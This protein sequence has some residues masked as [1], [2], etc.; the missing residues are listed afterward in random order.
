MKV[1]IGVT[2]YD[3]TLVSNETIALEFEQAE[4][5]VSIVGGF[6]YPLFN[7]IKINKTL[8]TQGR[9]QTFLHEATHAMLDEIGQ[10]ELYHDEAFVNA[11]SKQIYGLFKNNNFEK[12]YK[13]LGDK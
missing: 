1:Q 5:D 2:D 13:F 10:E 12:I 9:I 7:Q 6:V 3:M 11:M 4:D 8:P